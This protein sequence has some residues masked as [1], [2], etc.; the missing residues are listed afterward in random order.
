MPDGAPE[1]QAW[2]EYAAAVL[3][4]QAS[5]TRETRRRLARA[6]RRWVA[7]FVSAQPAAPSVVIPF[8]KTGSAK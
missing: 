2:R 5:D 7:G 1:T 4:Q 3:A 8:R 6:Y